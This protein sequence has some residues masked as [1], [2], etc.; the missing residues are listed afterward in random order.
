VFGLF[1]PFGTANVEFSGNSAKGAPKK[2]IISGAPG[3]LSN[4]ALFRAQ[5]FDRIS[6]GSFDGLITDCQQC[7]GHRAEAGSG[8]Y[9]PRHFHPIF[10]PLQ[11]I[12]HGIVRNGYGYKECY[13]DQE[14][15][16]TRKHLPQ[17][18]NGCSQNFFNTDLFCTLLG[19]ERSKSEDAKGADQCR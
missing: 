18:E 4:L 14:N 5:T 13:A 19:H 6:S 17:L 7:D 1:F 3:L 8:K 11:P 10:K 16:I 12:A 9:P 2:P 15:K